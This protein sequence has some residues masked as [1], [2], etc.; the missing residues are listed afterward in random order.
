MIIIIIWGHGEFDP[1]KVISNKKEFIRS[2]DNFT[3]AVF[4]LHP[5]LRVYQFSHAL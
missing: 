5:Y 3:V 4:N 2:D 1:S